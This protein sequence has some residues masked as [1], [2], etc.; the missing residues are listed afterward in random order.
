MLIVS[1]IRS[2]E[3]KLFFY[4]QVPYEIIPGFETSSSLLSYL[5]YELAVNPEIQKK[6][7]QEIK[8][9]EQES[10][11]MLTYDG[12]QKLSYLDQVTSE[13]LRKWP[14][15]IITDRVCSKS[16]NLH[17]DGKE[18]EIQEKRMFLIPIY[19][20]HHDPKYFPEPDKFDPKRFSVEN[21]R[22]ITDTGAF[23][24]FG[25]GKTLKFGLFLKV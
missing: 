18:I 15:S 25:I 1:S 17:V 23:M 14:S 7:R 5:T 24:P 21:R 4:N 2:V 11:G 22:N 3:K 13:T 16:L 9:T 20:I 12:L 19:G 6:L 8:A 10:G